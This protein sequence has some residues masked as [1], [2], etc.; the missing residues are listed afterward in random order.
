MKINWLLAVLVSLVVSACASS[1]PMVT[2]DT[3]KTTVQKTVVG[4]TQASVAA[5]TNAMSAADAYAS[6]LAAQLQA[7]QK[8]SIY[9]DFDEF[10]IK[11]EY[12]E[13]V[14]QQAEFIKSHGDIIVKLE[15]NA[16]ERGSSEYNLALGD[17][18]ANA[19]R[20]LLDMMGVPASQLRTVSKGEEYPRLT[21]HEEKCWQENRRVDFIGKSGL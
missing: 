12:R 1:P 17:K 20:K 18:R 15:G 19:V 13:I 8:K 3:K 11:P 2:A 16:D 21:C 4:D 14:Q 5:E 10:A 9:F 7:M 6:K